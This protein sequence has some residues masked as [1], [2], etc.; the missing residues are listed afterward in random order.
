MSFRTYTD[1]SISTIYIYTLF[2]EIGAVGFWYVLRTIR[3]TKTPPVQVHVQAA[4]IY[5]SLLSAALRAKDSADEYY[6]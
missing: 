6:F 4:Y 5:L 2:F 1:P 3:H